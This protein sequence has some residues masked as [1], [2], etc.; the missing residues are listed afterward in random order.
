MIT[1]KTQDKFDA[2]GD[3]SF[4]CESENSGFEV[5]NRVLGLQGFEIDIIDW[6]SMPWTKDNFHTRSGLQIKQVWKEICDR[7]YIIYGENVLNAFSRTLTADLQDKMEGFPAFWQLIW[8]RDPPY[9]GLLQQSAFTLLEDILE[10]HEQFATSA[11]YACKGWKCSKQK[12]GISVLDL[13]CYSKETWY[14]FSSV[15]RRH[16]FSGRMEL[17]TN[18]LANVMWMA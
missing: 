2:S 8:Q 9:W 13:V 6:H 17:V 4:D 12:Q 11:W 18:L 16:T 15:V 7:A 10:E 14:S 1:R 5:G 3:L